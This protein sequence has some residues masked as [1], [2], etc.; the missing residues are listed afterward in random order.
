[1]QNIATTKTELYTKFL[2]EFSIINLLF[3]KSGAK[4]AHQTPKKRE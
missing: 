4:I 3:F 2:T 1:M